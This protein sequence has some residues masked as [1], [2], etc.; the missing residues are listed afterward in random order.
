MGS[1]GLRVLPF[2]VN[3]TDVYC[4]TEPWEPRDNGFVWFLNF[5]LAFVFP[6]IPWELFF[7][8]PWLLAF[9]ANRALKDP[10]VKKGTMGHL[11]LGLSLFAG[12]YGGLAHPL[13][14]I[15]AF[16][17]LA[18]FEGICVVH[19]PPTAIGAV[20][21]PFKLYYGFKQHAWCT[22]LAFHVIS[23]SVVGWY[24]LY[25]LN[26][27]RKANKGSGLRFWQTP[28]ASASMLHYRTGMFMLI[29]GLSQA[30]P[31]F[32]E[33]GTGYFS[34]QLV[35]TGGYSKRPFSPAISENL[36]AWSWIIGG[37]YHFYLMSAAKEGSS[38]AK[39]VP[40]GSAA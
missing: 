36:S 10:S 26:K 3:S 38:T 19:P 13:G 7:F 33:F 9:L 6:I 31:Y 25:L 27:D 18:G 17:S 1:L 35:S 8:V 11:V 28:N 39:V 4:M 14:L 20:G 16:S 30:A 5:V 23:V 22:L 15:Q 21:P 32:G 40:S 29:G 2:C 12:V 37:L 24:F 34:S